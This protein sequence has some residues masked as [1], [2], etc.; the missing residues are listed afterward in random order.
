MRR[1]LIALPLKIGHAIAKLFL[2]GEARFGDEGGGVGAA[3]H[4]LAGGILQMH[5]L[6]VGAP[7]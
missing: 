4:H 3:C 2:G 5:R 7:R 6:A 1:P